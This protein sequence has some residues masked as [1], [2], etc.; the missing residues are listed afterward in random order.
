MKKSLFLILM[1]MLLIFSVSATGQQETPKNIVRVADQVPNLITP[2]VW[3]GQTFS[4]NCTIYEYLV[5]L[6]PETNEVIPCLAKDWSTTDGKVWTLK[7]QEGVK[8]HD[9]SDF[10]SE[11]VKFTIERT[12][13][14]DLG[15]LQKADFQIV[16]SIETPDDYTVVLTLKEVRPTFIYL[17][18]A[19]NMMMLSSDY[20]YASLGE[21][22]P[23]GTGA[24]KMAELRPKESALL[25]KNEEYWVAG[26]PKADELRIYFVPDIDASMNMLE[27]GKVDIAPFATVIH[28]DRLEAAGFEVISPYQEHRFVALAADREP[29]NDNRVR[30]AMKYCMD[31]EV[32]AAACQGELGVDIFYNESP[33]LNNQSQ[34]Y[35]I[36]FR[37]QDIEKAKELLA[38][39]GYPNGLS[40]ELYYGSDHPFGKELTQTIKELAAPAG[41]DVQLKGYSR[42]VY[43]SQYW[44]NA[45]MLLT[46]WGGRP[47]PSMLLMLAYH[48]EGPWNESHINEP[49]VD[50]L[51]G[52]ILA[53]VDDTV[54]QGY[55]D[56]L[57]KVFYDRGTI[58]NIQVPYYVALRKEVKDYSQP[59]TFVTRYKETYI[60]E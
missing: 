2:G 6:D 15:H 44:M 13:D 4:M 20:D 42:D 37:G 41:F 27:A 1:A 57:A 43:L 47:D 48:S 19:Y 39:A 54:R 28:K 52:K 36:P 38:E 55:Y 60:S 45:P 59:M 24:F 7:L 22:Q 35:D 16:E 14:P 34:Y 17:F 33:I 8:F 23:M 56:E 49:R 21:S 10:T 12:Q 9:G 29:F 31:P 5:E 46:G 30:Q 58:L 11:D 3:D 32:L 40:V 18:L 25:V 51:I 26:L 53:E 50:E